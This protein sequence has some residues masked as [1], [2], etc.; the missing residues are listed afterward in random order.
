[1]G[2]PFPYVFFGLFTGWIRE[3]NS[4][5]LDKMFHLACP[6]SEEEPQEKVKNS[7]NRYQ[8]SAIK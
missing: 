8:N 3:V 6:D 5:D 1:M 2:F 7:T 4:V